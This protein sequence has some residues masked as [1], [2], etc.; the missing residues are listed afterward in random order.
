MN[1]G[2]INGGKRKNEDKSRS[3]WEESGIARGDTK[4]WA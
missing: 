2:D 3:S 4:L 1:S